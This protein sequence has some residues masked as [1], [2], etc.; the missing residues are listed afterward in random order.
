MSAAVLSAHQ[1]RQQYDGRTVLH[2]PLFE[3]HAG[4]IV[5]IAGPNGSGKS[6]LLR[7]LAL[8]E[9]PAAGE[10]RMDGTALTQADTPRTRRVTLLNQHPYLFR[11]NVFQNVTY[12][13][14]AQGFG[15]DLKQRAE[16]ALRMVHLSPESFLHRSWY[17]LS[18]GEA[19]R[20]ALAA[21]LALRPRVLLLDEPTA[22]LDQEST[23]AIRLAVQ[24]ACEQW[25]TA[26]GVVSH[27]SGWLDELCHEVFWMYAGTISGTGRANVLAGAWEA[28]PAGP[29]FR[30][31]DGQ[32][33]A[34]PPLPGGPDAPQAL[35]PAGAALLVAPELLELAPA[36]GATT[37]ATTG[38]TADAAATD[39]ATG[40]TTDTTPGVT[41]ATTPGVPTA[42]TTGADSDANTV[43]PTCA[44]PGASPL[45]EGSAT[46]TE[47]GK[48]ATAH[49]TAQRDAAPACQT[50]EAR[51]V[52]T[53]A[54]PDG[55]VFARFRV[56]D[57]GLW[58]RLKDGGA[59]PAAGLRARLGIPSQAMRWIGV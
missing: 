13:L 54:R 59:L 31:S 18:G 45:F 29:A 36:P 9:R 55:V 24:H 42:A 38:A 30:F 44:T 22:S 26:V 50:L 21:R 48:T 58:M 39:S 37:D 28:L 53:I 20:V 46:S 2:L 14:R 33:L 12:G 47:S 35:P 15:G 19:Q 32:T 43:A 52:Q 7:C 56:G 40:V 1:L 41:T 5:G 17:A 4:R 3:L 11:K 16:E 57:T 27:D 23:E 34:A 8:L 49:D 25:N 51:L 10:M 6:T